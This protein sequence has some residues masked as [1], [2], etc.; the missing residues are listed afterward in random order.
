MGNFRF[1][2]FPS[3][4]ITKSRAIKIGNRIGNLKFQKEKKSKKSTNHN[5]LQSNWYN[6]FNF[7]HQIITIF[8]E[9]FI[10]DN[11]VWACVTRVRPCVTWRRRRN[12]SEKI[13]I[14]T[15]IRRVEKNKKKHWKKR[16]HNKTLWHF[17]PR[18]R[19]TLFLTRFQQNFFDDTLIT[20]ISVP[21][22]AFVFFHFEISAFYNTYEILEQN[23]HW[24]FCELQK[25]W[26]K[27]WKYFLHLNIIIKRMFCLLWGKFMCSKFSSISIKTKKKIF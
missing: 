5:N 9:I 13:T 23:V 16:I 21:N 20:K 19:K 24:F 15:L 8:Q 3:N 4:T 1:F 10:D 18:S 17:V 7:W 26:A 14:W 22:S 27:Y 12:F 6:F 11:S 2:L 25:K